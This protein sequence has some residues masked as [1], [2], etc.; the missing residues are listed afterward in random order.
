MH[1]KLVVRQPVPPL[2]ASPPAANA[3][4]DVRACRQ[5]LL[6]VTMKPADAVQ[7]LWRLTG[8]RDG[9]FPATCPGQPDATSA[10]GARET[11]L[12]PPQK[13]R[14]EPYCFAA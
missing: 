11:T 3:G 9:A 2:C 13:K 8:V 5:Q 6:I 1:D 7:R 4:S 12:N 14:L 10:F